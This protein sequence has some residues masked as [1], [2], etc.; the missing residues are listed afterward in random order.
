MSGA[1]DTAIPGLARGLDTDSQCVIG[2]AGVFTINAKYS[3]GKK[4][5]AKGYGVLVDG[6]GT[7]H[8]PKA[9]AEARRALK[10]NT[11]KPQQAGPQLGG[12]G[13]LSG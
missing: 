10:A 4:V 5:W 11:R 13:C 3:P 8:V 9:I 1:C 2:P 7:G 6:H 12:A